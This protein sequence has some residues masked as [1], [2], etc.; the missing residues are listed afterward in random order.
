MKKKMIF[1][2]KIILL[3]LFIFFMSKFLNINFIKKSHF[4]L[5]TV[6]SI[7]SGFLFTSL[8]ILLG[9][10]NEGIIEFLEEG[11]YLNSIYGNITKGLVFS[12]VSI[13]ISILNLTI[14]ESYS[15]FVNA[16]KYLYSAEMIFLIITIVKFIHAI[17]DLSFLIS[18]IRTYKKKKI[19]ENK[20]N[21]GLDKKFNKNNS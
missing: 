19:K 8:S 7:F 5:I 3:V 6:N 21:R 10:N 17:I 13:V 20:A 4:D 14:F 18:N 11:D 12:I 9:F 15:Y 1:L 16:L 2:V